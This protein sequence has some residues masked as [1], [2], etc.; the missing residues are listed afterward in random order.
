M[1]KEIDLIAGH[2][3]SLIE[4]EVR[5]VSYALAQI[6]PVA[7]RYGINIGQRD[8]PY[9]PRTELQNNGKRNFEGVG[10][11]G[12]E[13]LGR[14]ARDFELPVAA[15][16][17][18]AGDLPHFFHNLDPLRDITWA[19][20][21][22]SQNYALLAFLGLTPFNIMVKNPLHGVLPGQAKGSLERI[23]HPT[24]DENIVSYYRYIVRSYPNS[25][26]SNP[27]RKLVYCIRGYE[28]PVTPDGRVDEEQK[29]RILQ[30]LH[31]YRGSRNVNNIESIA[32][33]R[34]LEYF[35]EQGIRIFFDPSHVFGGTVSNREAQAGITSNKLRRLIGEYAIKSITE[36]GYDGLLI[37]VHDTSKHAKTDKDQALV[38]TYNGV[39]YSETNMSEK[40]AEDERPLSLVDI[41]KQLMT[42]QVAS[43]NARVSLERLAEDHKSLD[44]IKWNRVA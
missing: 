33:L 23:T 19:G 25:R 2:C 21:R 3:S 40:P 1:I 37:E 22:D 35:Q 43:G 44:A 28:W 31:Q 12:L 6:K 10:P 36:F 26:I 30:R 17:M 5:S 39:D 38:I 7:K 9:K 20:A 8:G 41:V 16:I 13:W 27:S 29:E 32:T 24:T 34:N 15:E 11:V 42:H 18:Y 4:S 14:A